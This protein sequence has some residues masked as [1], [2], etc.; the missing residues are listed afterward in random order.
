[1]IWLC[2]IVSEQLAYHL[3]ASGENNSEVEA[4]F[5]DSEISCSDK[6]RAGDYRAP[7]FSA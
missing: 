6:E 4:L 3:L 1:M 2:S 5:G 7:V